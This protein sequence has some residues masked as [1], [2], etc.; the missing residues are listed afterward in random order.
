MITCWYWTTAFHS[1]QGSLSGGGSPIHEEVTFQKIF[2]RHLLHRD[3]HFS[4]WSGEKYDFH[5]QCDLV[6]VR[7]HDFANGLGI[8]IHIRTKIHNDW[9]AVESAAIKIGD[10]VFE[11]SGRAG[12][13][14]NGVADSELPALL[15]GFEVSLGKPGPNTRR[16]VV[17]L[18]DGQKI[19]I[20]TFKEFLSVA[21]EDPRSLRGVM[22]F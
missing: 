18:G 11:I 14:L 1:N 2:L 7:N 5:G 17:H 20:T 3:P 13:W 6:L 4:T 19:R 8:D 21:I 22:D 16:F 12:H 9:S 10:E 15:G